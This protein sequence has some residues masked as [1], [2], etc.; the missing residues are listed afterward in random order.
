[1]PIP[2]PFDMLNDLLPGDK[3]RTFCEYSLYGITKGTVLT[4]KAYVRGEDLFPD[5]AYRDPM[6]YAETE[7][8][9]AELAGW[10]V[11]FE[12]VER[13]DKEFNILTD[14]LPG[15]KIR[16]IGDNSRGYKN[17][18]LYTFKNYPTPELNVEEHD[19]SGFIKYFEFVERPAS[20]D[21]FKDFKPG[22]K[23]RRIGYNHVDLHVGDIVTFKNYHSA[24]TLNIE[25]H[26]YAM[27]VDKFELVKIPTKEQEKEMKDQVQY[28]LTALN[29][30]EYLFQVTNQPATDF[31]FKDSTGFIIHSQLF[32]EVNIGYNTVYLKGND[33]HRT[34][35]IIQD[36]DVSKLSTYLDRM[37]NAIK[38]YNVSITSKD[39]HKEEYIEAMKTTIKEYV[40]GSHVFDVDKCA[41]CKVTKKYN[42]ICNCTICPWLVITGHKCKAT[43][44]AKVNER[45]TE[46]LYWIEKYKA[47]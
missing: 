2:T 28:T 32:P 38:E 11:S 6:V 5:Q 35:C 1:M 44:A 3:I 4:F 13:P 15:D 34:M 24:K 40:D 46:L 39:I 9:T 14:L 16:R 10:I 19:I 25:E 22:D 12:F 29:D 18:V 33:K 42:D 47:M 21:I 7:E 8:M 41:L 30:N 23:I 31:V 43:P 45:I 37:K 27:Y 17:N 20:F 36:K 26:D